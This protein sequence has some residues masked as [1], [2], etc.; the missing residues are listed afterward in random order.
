MKFVVYNENTRKIM[1]ELCP[2]INK[3]YIGERGEN[4][5]KTRV[6]IIY[7]GR[8]IGLDEC[9]ILPLTVDGEIGVLTRQHAVAILS[10]YKDKKPVAQTMADALGIKVSTV[11]NWTKTQRNQLLSN[12]DLR[13][14]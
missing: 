3:K 2:F 10:Q 13:V 9:S 7:K 8:L 6:D 11:L 5:R 12:M 1:Q 14:R 4:N